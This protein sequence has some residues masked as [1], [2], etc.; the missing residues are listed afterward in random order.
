MNALQL[1]INEMTDSYWNEYDDSETIW[2][3]PSNTLTFGDFRR[4]AAELSNYQA[5]IAELEGLLNRAEG[6]VGY[7]ADAIDAD[8]EEI[9]LHKEITAALQKG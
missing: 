3:K 8:E 6:F 1:V 5:R 7:M 2:G 4:A 9:E